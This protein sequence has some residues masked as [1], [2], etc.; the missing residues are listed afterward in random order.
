MINLYFNQVPPFFLMCFNFRC[1]SNTLHRFYKTLNT[2]TYK[3][4]MPT[5]VTCPNVGSSLSTTVSL[6][7]IVTGSFATVKYDTDFR[8]SRRVRI[9]AWYH[10]ARPDLWIRIYHWYRTIPV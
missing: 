3:H 5:F 1:V 7:N 4:T 10:S 2:V 6:V 8:S 9:V